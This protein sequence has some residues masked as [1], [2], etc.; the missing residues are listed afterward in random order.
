M[1]FRPLG[2]YFGSHQVH[3]SLSNPRLSL[4]GSRCFLT[5]PL[6]SHSLSNISQCAH[7]DALSPLRNQRPYRVRPPFMPRHTK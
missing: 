3:F 1:H 5:A 4:T 7:R 2:G 6:L